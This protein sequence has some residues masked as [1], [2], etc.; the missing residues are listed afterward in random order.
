MYHY[1]IRPEKVLIYQTKNLV[2]QYLGST[3][4]AHRSH[5]SCMTYTLGHYRP[6][7]QTM[8]MLSIAINRAEHVHVS[9]T[10]I[11]KHN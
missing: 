9:A 6:I 5:E 10:V 8:F 11:I 1:Y 4:V 2:H 3:S 7:L